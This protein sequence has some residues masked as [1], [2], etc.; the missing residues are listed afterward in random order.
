MAVGMASATADAILNAIGNNTS[1]VIATPYMQLHTA[2]PGTAGTTSVATE[3]SR[4]LVS[5]G[6]PQ[7]GAAGF[8]KIVND[9]AVTWV[10]IAGS[11]DAT[12]FSLWDASTSGNYLGSGVITAAAYT[13][14]DTYNIAIG[15]AELT[16]PINT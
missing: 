15:A 16:L 5:F 3:T 13:A 4:K 8:R 7:A 2:E 1:Y 14:G 10:A 12:H 9:A 11:Q 6:A